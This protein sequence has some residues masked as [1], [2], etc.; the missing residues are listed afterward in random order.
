[1][2]WINGLVEGTNKILLGRLKHLCSPNLNSDIDV[3]PNITPGDI[4][5]QWPKH[6]EA[7]ITWLNNRILPAL[8]HSPNKLALGLVV[9]SASDP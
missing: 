9:N 4:L 1:S 6:F 3:I 7:V 5:R 8:H 2:A